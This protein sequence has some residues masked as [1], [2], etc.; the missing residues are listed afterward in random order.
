MSLEKWKKISMKKEIRQMYSLN[1]FQQKNFNSLRKLIEDKI[2]PIIK[3]KVDEYNLTKSEISQTCADQANIGLKRETEA[4]MLSNM[5]L[6]I[7]HSSSYIRAGDLAASK[8]PNGLNPYFAVHQTYHSFFS[9]MF[10][11]MVN[12]SIPGSVFQTPYFFSRR[13]PFE[14]TSM[15]GIRGTIQSIWR[16]QTIA[17]I[18]YAS[19]Q[20]YHYLWYKYNNLV[21]GDFAIYCL[22]MG[23]NCSNPREYVFPYSESSFNTLT[24]I[25]EEFIIIDFFKLFW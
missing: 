9:K 17:K 19:L 18:P 21:S 22:H 14:E 25:R 13:N 23:S 12:G 7:D 20:N 10:E 2:S 15:D 3:M 24:K 1:M 16:Q 8:L 5:F 11:E 4:M 6:F